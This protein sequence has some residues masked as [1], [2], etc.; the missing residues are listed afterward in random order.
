M[1][2]ASGLAC[3]RHP[4]RANPGAG[5]RDRVSGG[6][7]VVEERQGASDEAA[8]GRR[9]CGGRTHLGMDGMRGR[10]GG[11]SA[12][13]RAAAKGRAHNVQRPRPRG[14]TSPP[15]A[16]MAAPAATPVKIRRNHGRDRGHHFKQCF[17]L[18]NEVQI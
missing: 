4:R 9:Q 13:R 2:L 7:P 3:R 11:A 1:G 15:A 17:C 10:M 18:N 8:A 14:T 5:G 12:G 6:L 16:I